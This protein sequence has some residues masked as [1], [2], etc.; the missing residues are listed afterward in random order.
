M[1]ELKLQLA[2]KGRGGGIRWVRRMGKE[3]AERGGEV[4]KNHGPSLDET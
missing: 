2:E 3:E 4:E 1:I